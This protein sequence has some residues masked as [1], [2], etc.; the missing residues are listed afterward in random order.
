[1][2]NWEFYLG[3]GT[4]KKELG[5]G[6]WKK[7]AVTENAERNWRMRAEGSMGTD[8]SELGQKGLDFM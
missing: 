3:K 5:G 7:I 1:M 2:M 8:L 4:R 6:T